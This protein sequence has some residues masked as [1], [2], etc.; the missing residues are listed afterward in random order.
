MEDVDGLR[1]SYS[2]ANYLGRLTTT[3]LP[4]IKLCS[5][6]CATTESNCTQ[7]FYR[8]ATVFCSIDRSQVGRFA[9][10]QVEYSLTQNAQW[11]HV[12]NT[13]SRG[14]RDKYFK[15]VIF[16]L[17]CCLYPGSVHP[18]T[19]PHLRETARTGMDKKKNDNHPPPT[20]LLSIPSSR[21][22]FDKTPR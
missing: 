17:F 2:L 7:P 9:C 5:W 1:H 6:F 15:F 3:Y 21:L 14:F 22:R 11:N 13:R 12:S 16:T 4:H 18:S 20:P 19:C 8:I 10:W